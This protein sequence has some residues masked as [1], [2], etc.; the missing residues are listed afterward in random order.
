MQTNVER[1]ALAL[2]ALCTSA[3]TGIAR[4][5]SF[6]VDIGDASAM[7]VPSSN[8]GA[9]AGQAG[10]W[11]GVPV[12]QAVTSLS[13][14]NGD[15]TNV[16][17]RNGSNFAVTWNHAGTVGDDEA[18]LDDLGDPGSSGLYR[19]DGLL[20]GGYELWTYAWAPDSA[21]GLSSVIVTGATEPAATVGGAWSGALAEGITHSVHH[22]NVTSGTVFIDVVPAAEPWVQ[23]RPEGGVR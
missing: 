22:L 10:E 4:P 3:S 15:P 23:S 8:Y 1:T 12:L 11:N 16:V 20:P 17:F 6:N 9:A 7:G 18:L 14:L 21:A 19:F 2:I 13:D 5:Q